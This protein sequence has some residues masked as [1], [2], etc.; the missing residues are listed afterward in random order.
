MCSYV[1]EGAFVMSLLV[2][3]HFFFVLVIVIS[4]FIAPT[5]LT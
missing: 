1:C 2:L 5:W 4:K 3:E